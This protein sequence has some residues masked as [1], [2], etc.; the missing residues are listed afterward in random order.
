MSMISRH[1]A[2]TGASMV[3]E[4]TDFTG[5]FSSISPFFA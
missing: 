2:A 3:I 4:S 5:A 1:T